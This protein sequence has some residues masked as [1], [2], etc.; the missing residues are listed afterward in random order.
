MLKKKIGL[1]LGG[2]GAKGF[3][4]IGVLK[5]LEEK[6]IPID[7]VAGTSIGAI[8]GALYCLGYSSFEIEKIAKTTKFKQLFDLTLPKKGL[9]K[10]EKIEIYLKHLFENK[11]FSDLKKPLFVVST[12]IINFHEVIFNKGD[13]TKAVRASISIPGIFHPVPNKNKI[14]VDGGVLNNLPIDVLQKKADSII[15]V[16]LEKGK[17]KQPIYETANSKKENTESINIINILLNSYTMIIANQLKN[18]ADNPNILILSP[19][20]EKISIKDFNKSEQG[21]LK[22]YEIAKKNFNKIKVLLKKEN[23]LEKIFK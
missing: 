8:I 21:I 22:G 10:G 15:A 16:N 13:L 3:A 2:G 18:M 17:I 9:I 12:D 19:D 23:L 1:V 7:Y 4:H 20:L 14:L 6:N 11:K 5:F